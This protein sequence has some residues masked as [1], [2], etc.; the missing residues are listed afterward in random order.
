LTFRLDY[1]ADGNMTWGEGGG[2]DY[3]YVWDAENRLVG[4]QWR[5]VRCADAVR[6]Q[7]RGAEKGTLLIRKDKG[8]G[9]FCDE[10]R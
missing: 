10:K 9:V 3:D 2:F 6:E 1:D 8:S 7:K 5:R 4:V